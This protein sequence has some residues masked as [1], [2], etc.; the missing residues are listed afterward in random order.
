MQPNTSFLSWLR[1]QIHEVRKA[2]AT[3]KNNCVLTKTIIRDDEGAEIAYAVGGSV[4]ATGSG[5]RIASLRNGNLCTQ[6]GQLFGLL[7]PS[8]AVR[9]SAAAAFMRLAKEG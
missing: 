9:G 7:T 1:D 3:M 2:G 8:G 5:G 4:Y 6:D